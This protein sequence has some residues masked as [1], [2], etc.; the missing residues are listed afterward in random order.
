M[1]RNLIK[2]GERLDDL[3]LNNLKL[4]QNPNWFCFGV[5]AVLLSDFA[6]KAI[7]KNSCVVDF[8]S[9]NGVIPILL[10]AKTQAAFF[11]GLEI[12]ECVAELA[13]RNV[14]FNRL[15]DKIKIDCES[16][17]SADR[18]IQKASVDYIT[19]NPPYKK[20]DCGIK[21]E[22]DIIT[23]ARHEVKCT[24][25]DILVSAEKILKPGGKIALIH[26][27][28]RLIDIVWLMKKNNI[29]PKRLRFVHPTPSKTASMIL[30]EGTKHGGKN[31]VLEPPLYIYDENHN[32]T[33]EIDRI[34]GKI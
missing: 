32:Y 20:L 23:I 34:Y 30:V 3:Q 18:L 2:S 33:K 12:Q 25:E 15:E 8:C 28:E 14:C 4:I 10:S 29:E 31:L 19:C 13:M 11:W 6:S 21:N 17:C 26:R 16:L 9:G 24:L 7:K 27:P 1:N 5:D 22:N